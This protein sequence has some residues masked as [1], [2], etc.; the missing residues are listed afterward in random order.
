MRKG[1][2]FT[3]QDVAPVRSLKYAF[4]YAGIK[5]N[6]NVGGLKSAQRAMKM[7]SKYFEC[8][9]SSVVEWNREE[10][11]TKAIPVS[12]TGNCSGSCPI[13]HVSVQLPGEE[14]QM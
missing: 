12:C 7:E 10:C 8:N 14:K 1:V 6:G 5:N 9:P 4:C 13:V 11:L 3:S 2:L